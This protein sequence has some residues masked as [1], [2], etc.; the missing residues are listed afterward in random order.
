MSNM[1]D[2]LIYIL[3]IKQKQNLDQRGN[4]PYTR[5]WYINPGFKLPLA[6]YILF[7]I[8]DQLTNFI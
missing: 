4:V 3:V 6:E 1:W 5:R 7:K 2:Q 8:N